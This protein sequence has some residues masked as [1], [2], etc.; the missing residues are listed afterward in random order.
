MAAA[1][2]HFVF[3]TFLDRDSCIFVE[4]GAGGRLVE[5]SNRALNPAS[6]GL[7]PWSLV[8]PA[9]PL[10]VLVAVVI[11]RRTR[12]W[13]RERPDAEVVISRC[14]VRRFVVVDAY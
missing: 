1:A 4:T 7:C 5:L 13:N 11:R 14:I 10:A 9:R 8:T 12:S 2:S 3:S 6:L